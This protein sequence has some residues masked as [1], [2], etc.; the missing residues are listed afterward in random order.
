MET[1]AV[2][3]DVQCEQNLRAF[4]LLLDSV[5]GSLQIQPETN[6]LQGCARSGVTIELCHLIKAQVETIKTTKNKINCLVQA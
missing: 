3:E 1:F 2:F 6:L 4:S 5:E